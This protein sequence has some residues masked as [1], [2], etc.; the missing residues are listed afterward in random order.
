MVFDDNAGTGNGVQISELWLYDDPDE[1]GYATRIEP[2]NRDWTVSSHST[3]ENQDENVEK[4]FDGYT[5]KFLSFDGFNGN[6]DIIIEFP[7]PREIR[8]YQWWT[9]D[10][11]LDPNNGDCRTPTAWHWLASTDGE[12]WIE[13]AR[14]SGFDPATSNE[15]PAECA[16]NAY[17]K[18]GDWWLDYSKTHLSNPLASSTI[19]IDSGAALLI[20]KAEAV[21]VGNIVNNG[22]AVE[23][24]QAGS[25]LNVGTDSTTYLLGGGVTGP[26]GIEKIGSGT[27]R[28][29]G[30]N[31]Y[32]GDTVISEGTYAIVP[33]QTAA[34]KFFRFTF[35]NRD[36]DNTQFAWL[37]LC[38][39]DGAIQSTGLTPTNLGTGD[40][41]DI[42]VSAADLVPG[43]YSRVTGFQEWNPSTESIEQ[44][45]DENENTKYGGSP[46]GNECQIVFRLKDDAAPIAWYDVMSGGDDETN[47]DRRL[48]NFRLEASGDGVSWQ[49]VSSVEVTDR[50]AKNK[51]WYSGGD[52]FYIRLPSATDAT[53][54]AESTVEVKPGATLV[55]NTAM[56][57]SK[58]R[59][60]LDDG[61]AT[62]GKIIGFTPALNG[63]LELICTDAEIQSKIA[64]YKDIPI[65]LDFES[66]SATARAPLNKWKCTLNGNRCAYR[67]VP[68][69]GTGNSKLKPMGSFTMYI[70]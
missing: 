44:I 45:F 61:N 43:T 6:A 42:G 29:N 31:T 7:E 66:I 50:T 30:V 11:C 69:E 8:A 27:T 52:G 19:T 58:L 35:Q 49:T 53:I 57:I 55:V 2:E 14:V 5:T 48:T 34:P 15:N 23:L 3:W 25:V 65:A 46:H 41:Q 26:G 68:V 38:S 36:H 18:A 17:K 13:V 12:S 4:L 67:L 22:G 9:A 21:K 51:A 24:T 64:A 28:A 10:D 20:D 39:A 47:S 33:S 54:P 1:D 63:R 37:K 56:T 70:R 16:T 59:I 60:N 40:K 32:T 62:P